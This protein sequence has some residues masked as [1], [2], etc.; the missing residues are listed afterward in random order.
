MI[1]ERE[2]KGALGRRAFTLI[3]VLIVIAILLALFGI[4]AGTFLKAGEKADVNLQKVQLEAIEDAMARFRLDMKRYPTEEEGL[5]A[6]WDKTVLES[7]EDEDKWGGATS[8]SPSPRINGA[9]TCSI[10]SRARMRPIRMTSSPWGRTVK[11]APR[12]TSRTTVAATPTMR[13][14]K[15]SRLRSER[16]RSHS[17]VT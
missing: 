6:L 3:E 5:E 10:T 4:V 1:V 15:T 16:A 9:T 8:K 17:L 12:T 2:R 13:V 14:S 7:E 11:K